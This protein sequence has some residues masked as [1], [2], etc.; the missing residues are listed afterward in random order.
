MALA[1]GLPGSLKGGQVLLIQAHDAGLRCQMRRWWRKTVVLP[2][3]GSLAD[4]V[5]LLSAPK[6]MLRTCSL[7]TKLGL[8]A[9]LT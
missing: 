4:R 7:P 9:W 6:S 3:K 5:R 8:S 2:G 1:A